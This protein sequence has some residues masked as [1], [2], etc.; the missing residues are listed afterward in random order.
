MPKILVTPRSITQHGHP[1]LDLLKK[2]GFEVIFSTPGK[3]PDEEELLRILP[4]CVGMLAGVEK[5][6]AKVL[7]A[8]KELKAISRNGTGIDNIDLKSA[9]K[10]DIKILRAEGANAQ[11]VAELTISLMFSLIR[12]IPYSNSQMK[13]GNWSRKQGIEIKGKTLGLIGCGKVGK[14]VSQLALG[15]DMK[16]I[17]FDVYKDKLFSPSPNFKYKKIEEVISS[18]DILSLHCPMPEDHKPILT[19]ELI[20]KMKK[21]VY[22]I[23]TARAGLINED[24]LLEALK[25]FQITGYATDVYNEEPPVLNDLLKHENVILTPHIGGYTIESVEN[26]SR[27][28]VENL[29]KEL[30]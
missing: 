5:I 15:L 4:G 8:A 25:N 20:S 3:Q 10:L 27:A 30:K 9:E 29:L 11:G 14:I 6:S 22:L 26:A 19:K 16:V 13:Q 2:A 18:S 1:A 12:A 17:A 23:N 24:D 7:E 28:A 21:G